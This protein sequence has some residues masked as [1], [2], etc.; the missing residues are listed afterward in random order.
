MM[1]T[2]AK[3]LNKILA[4]NIQQY[5]KKIMHH[6]ENYFKNAKKN[7]PL[8]VNQSMSYTILT[9]CKIKI[10]RPFQYMQKK[11]LKKFHNYD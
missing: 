4:N 7:Q 8:L 1:N 10:I 9:K 2:N 6:N 3:S 5:I 11:H